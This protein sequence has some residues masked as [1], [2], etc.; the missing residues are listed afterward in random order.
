MRR[1]PAAL[2]TLGRTAR[3]R[4]PACGVGPL[5][6]GPF[7]M[8]RQCGHCGLS[9][10]R[11]PGFYLGSIYVNYGV[12]VIGTGLLYASMVLGLGTSH[13]AAFTAAL[14]VAVVLPVVF[15]R[16]A[17]AWLF[18][19]DHSVNRHQSAADLADDPA[20]GAGLSERHLA[21]L[22]DDDGRAG[23]MMGVVLVLILVFGLLMG[24]VTLFFALQQ[25]L[26]GTGMQPRGTRA[27]LMVRPSPRR[28]AR[29]DPG[30]GMTRSVPPASTP[31]PGPCV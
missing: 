14:V 8:H 7:T 22:Q 6:R 30:H 26:D 29:H 19:M 28:I 12:T 13:R 5:F 9:F 1:P 24:G 17:R 18:A 2:E 4:C 21:R 10:E 20:A 25:P 27:P 23:C 15:F 11:E 31:P 16:H 3:L